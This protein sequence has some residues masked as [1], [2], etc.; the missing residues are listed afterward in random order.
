MMP[1]FKSEFTGL[2]AE[3]FAEFADF[4]VPFVVTQ[5]QN[6]DAVTDTYSP[7]TPQSYTVTAIPTALDY[8]EQELYATANSKYIAL[9]S[10]MPADF[11]PELYTVTANSKQIECTAASND[12]ANATWSLIC[13]E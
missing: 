8:K 5:M 3:L 9:A 1:T 10:T 6:Y 2:A 13:R 7:A 12:A 11:K 4:A